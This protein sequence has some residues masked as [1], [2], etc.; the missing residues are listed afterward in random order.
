MWVKQPENFPSWKKRLLPFISDS[1]FEWM[2][3]RSI[4]LAQ[5]GMM[6][7]ALGLD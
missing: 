6:I 3:S 5:G 1:V 2:Y 7:G 4:L